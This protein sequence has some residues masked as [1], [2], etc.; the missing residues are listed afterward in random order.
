MSN[1]LYYGDHVDVLQAMP[2]ESVD[3]VYLDPPFNSSILE[4]R[5]PQLPPGLAPA[6]SAQSSPLDRRVLAIMATNMVDYSRPI[7]AAAADALVAAALDAGGKDNVSL[8]LVA[9]DARPHAGAS[10]Q[11]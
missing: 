2:A 10:Q 5:C 7:E 1:R 3:L 11:P 9:A 4:G 8:V 6:K